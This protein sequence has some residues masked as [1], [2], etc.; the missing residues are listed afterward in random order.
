MSEGWIKLYRKTLDNPLF[1]KNGKR[2]AVWV[3]LL[4]NA[5]HNGTTVMFE[6][7]KI[8]LKPGELTTG[9]RV[10]ASQL[11]V[12]ESF[13]QQTLTRFET[14][15][16]IKQRTDRQCRLISI[17][18]WNE[19]QDSEQ[20]NEQRL[21]NER[22]TNEQRLNTKQECK[23]V[24]M[25]EDSSA[26]PRFDDILGYFAGNGFASDPKAFYDYYNS[27]GWLNKYGK[28]ITNWKSAANMWERRE[29]NWQK[30]HIGK[31][32]PETRPYKKFEAEDYERPDFK[33][34]PMPDEVREK[35]KKLFNKE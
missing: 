27:T 29:K 21:N 1:K 20:P 32:Q 4:I 15:H 34:E 35:V 9:R 3:W 24:R 5:T 2:L 26:L 8:Q 13:V 28:P 22:T 18:K 25:K 19:Y 30:N 10:I 31:E 7:K 16:L 6:G 11:G 17:V 33:S 14:E 12:S 23:N